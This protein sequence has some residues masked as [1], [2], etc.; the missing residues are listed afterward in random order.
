MAEQESINL[1]LEGV[2]FAESM[3]CKVDGTEGKLY[4]RGYP[5][6]TL[7]EHSSF[8]EVSYLLLYGKL[9]T[10]PE[11]ESF[12]SLLASNRNIEPQV[13]E[14]IKSVAGKSHAMHILR[15][16][17][18][19]E[20]SLDKE[21]DD[22]APEANFR[23]S[24]RLIAKTGSIVA[25]IG[26]FSIG[27]K[28]VEPD[29]ALGHAEN[30]LYMLQG[31]KP[32]PEKAKM[33]DLMMVLH[34]EHSSNA[35]TFS[36]IVTGATLS[37]LY[38]AVVSGIGTLKGPLH[39]G[40]D[41]R[42]LKMLYDIGKPENTESYINGI[43]SSKERVM[44]FGHR[45]YKTYDPRA[46]IIK[47]Y[48]MKLQSD[49]TEEVQNLSG[50]ALAAEKIMVERLGKSHN[51]WPNVDF[52]SG[53]V[54]RHIGIPIEIFTP[55]FAVSRMPG[56]CAHMLEYWNNNRLIRPLDYYKGPLDLKYVPIEQR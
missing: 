43:L 30:F 19:M 37:D 2:Y 38:S 4:Y 41:E 15:T 23:K 25:A 48:L 56:W 45:V 20:A 36:T 50:I 26:R 12:S 24:A 5:I 52:F 51:I 34:A 1:G 53:P 9:P 21:A 6:E 13:L 31:E 33:L 28:Y 14:Y 29:K 44:G 10:K 54:Y 3:I 40:A 27:A 55:L 11:F 35:S 32:E 18:S 16:A 49:S 17:V 7:A 8:E 39:G 46:R 22:A 47:K 42:A